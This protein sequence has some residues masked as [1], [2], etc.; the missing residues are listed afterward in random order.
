MSNYIYLSISIYHTGKVPNQPLTSFVCPPFRPDDRTTVKGKVNSDA[1][2]SGSLRQ[3][4]SQFLELI[5]CAEVCVPKGGGRG[6][7]RV[8]SVN[9]I[10]ILYWAWSVQNLSLC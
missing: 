1:I 9:T 10:G 7:E 3:R 5:V 8:L 6:G 4:V 2:I